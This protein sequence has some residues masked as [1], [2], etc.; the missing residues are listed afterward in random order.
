M[1][2]HQNLR[3]SAGCPFDDS[4]FRPARHKVMMNLSQEAYFRHRRYT[5]Q[6]I[7]DVCKEIDRTVMAI[8]LTFGPKGMQA[9]VTHRVWDLMEG[10]FPT[11]IDFFTEIVEE[12]DP[13]EL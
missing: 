5:R 4:D 1:R 2:A 8:R 9:T 10:H 3:D 11:I 6:D 7:D 12:L 13:G